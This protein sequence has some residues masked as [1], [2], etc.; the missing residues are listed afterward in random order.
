MKIIFTPANLKVGDVFSPPADDQRHLLKVLRLRVGDAVEGSDGRQRLQCKIVRANAQ[1]E[2]EVTRVERLQDR[3]KV[4]LAIARIDT[5]RFASAFSAAAQM[6]V[7]EVFAVGCE[8]ASHGP[9]AIE[10]LNRVARESAKQVGCPFLPVLREL[11]G[12]AE[13]AKIIKDRPAFLLDPF[14]AKTL[15]ESFPYEIDERGILLIVG[16]VGDFTDAEKKDLCAAGAQPVQ[17][18]RE[19]LRSETAAVVALGVTATC[20]QTSR[21][22]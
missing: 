14:A 5:S 15:L 12:V 10:R 13:L 8:R 17:L 11:S 22:E 19:V 18:C 9:L 21:Q 6:A 1:V 2:L 20:I 4:S 16:P 3:R 7:K